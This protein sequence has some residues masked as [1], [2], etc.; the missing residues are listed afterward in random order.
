MHQWI[1]SKSI[2]KSLFEAKEKKIMGQNFCKNN[3]D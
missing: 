2:D 3:L 1:A